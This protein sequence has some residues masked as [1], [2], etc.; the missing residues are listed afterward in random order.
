MANFFYDGQIRRFVS[1]FIRLVSNFEVQFGKN[2]NGVVS[3]QRVP[4][5]YGDPSRQAAQ[6][7]RNNSENAINN[8]PMMSVYISGL[9]FDRDRVQ[10]PSFVGKINLREREFDPVTGTYGDKQGGI[11]TVE[12]LMPVPYKL[13]LK[14]DVWTSNTDQKLQIIEQLAGMFNPAME[15]QN[16]DNYIDWTSLTYVLLTDMNWTS[17][18]VPTGQEE[19]IDIITYTFEIP[20]W[21][22]SSI[23]VKQ[24]GVIRAVL[25][26]LEELP[27]LANLGKLKLISLLDYGVLLTG[28]NSSYNLRLLKNS[29]VINNTYDHATIS[30]GVKYSWAQ[31]L[32][33]FGVLQSGVTEVRLM[34]DNGY[35]IVGTVSSNPLDGKALLFS[36]FT[37]TLP[38]NTLS[39]INAIIDPE[40]IPVGSP[41]LSPSKG[42]R[43]MTIRDIG[44]Y[45]NVGTAP[46]AW[47]GKDGSDLVANMNDIIE[48]DGTRWTVS[49]DSS[50][51]ST[52]EY[53]TNLTTIIQYKWTNNQWTKSIEGAYASGQWSIA[54]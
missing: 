8:V 28:D 21:I 26:N 47:R 54:I 22:S 1:Q 34:Q 49:F 11:Y 48:F 45:E 30:A 13:T 40:K 23:K 16:T 53:V 51:C 9:V 5:I 46:L 29:H 3:N 18:S 39:P 38:A 14:M 31:V 15:I 43:Y 20:I 2:S 36:P 37:D 41:L 50:T 6:V 24:L 4:V 19:P 10:D 12:R 52:V 32:E 17:R 44:S 35:E 33:E 27:T 25:G 7:I 42:T